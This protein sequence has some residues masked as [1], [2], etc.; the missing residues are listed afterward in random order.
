MKGGM[1]F[2]RGSGKAARAYVEADHHRADDYYLSEGE[3]VAELLVVEGRSGEVV[4]RAPMD[5][6]DYEGWVQG[7]DVLADGQS[8]KGRIRNDDHALRFAEVVVNGP[9]SWSLAAGLHPDVAAAYDAAQDE[10]S[11]DIARWLGRNVTTRVGRRGDQRQVRAERVD[12]ARI[13]HFTT[14]AGDPHRHIH[15]QVNARVRAGGKWRGIDSAA[16]LRMQRAINGIGHRSVMSNPMFREALARHGYTLDARSGEIDQLAAVVPAM[17]KRSQQVAA[18]IERYTREWRADNPGLEPDAALLRTW[19]ARAWADEREAKKNHPTRGVECEQAWRAELAKL[20]VNVAGHQTAGPVPVAAVLPGA[21][22]RDEAAQRVVRVL[23]AG[24]RGRSMWNTYDVRGVAEEVLT[25]RGLV[26]DKAAIDEL[27]EDVVDRAQAASLVVVDQ[28]VPA[29]VRSMT[30]Q[31]VIDLERDIQGRLAARALE[32]AEL[33]EVAALATAAPDAQLD[34]A[35]LQAARTIAGTS[36]VV[37]VEGA[38][39]T[40]KSTMLAAANAAVVA[41]GHSMMVVAPS[42]NAALIAA[43]KVGAAHGP[44]AAGLAFQHGYRWDEDGVWSRLTPGD[45]CPLTDEP[46]DGP[47]QWAQLSPGDVLVIDEAGMLDQETARALLTVADEAQ[48]RV[49]FMGDRRQLP[50]VGRGG[51]MQVVADWAPA[52]VELDAVH[53]FR[54]PDGDRDA[55]YAELSQRMRSG[56]NPA[57]VFDELFAGGHVQLHETEADALAAIALTAADRVIADESQSIAVGT[58]EHAEAINQIVRERLV[59]A[60]IVD[61]DLT[62]LGSDGLRIGVGDQVV[63]RRNDNRLG[64]A[65]RMRWTVTAVDDAGAVILARSD[66]D[67]VTVEPDYVQ[68]NLHLAYASTAHGVQGD[69][70]DHGDKLLTDRTDAPAAYVGLTRG[71]QSNTLHVVARTL[72]DARE[73]WVAAAGRGRP[74]IGLANAQAIA[75]GEAGDYAL[76]DSVVIEEARDVREVLGVA[77]RH[78]EQQPVEQRTPESTQG[79]SRRRLEQI[80]ERSIARTARPIG[81]AGADNAAEVSQDP[82]Q[83]REANRRRWEQLRERSQTRAARPIGEQAENRRPGEVQADDG[84]DRALDDHRHER[85]GYGPRR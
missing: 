80:R 36:A 37:L 41:D 29:H 75:A 32:P 25:A 9:K 30:S 73:Q 47:A 49:V 14:R 83:R 17:S 64:I 84:H 26:A 78:S 34:P 16:L 40:G 77:P 18:N 52:P 79:P 23:A 13:R 28:P 51:I 7:R 60:G 68:A 63:T 85:G 15:L 5:G 11:E 48:A 43:E 33:I 65:N 8:P 53:R 72:D 58:N 22:D 6:D 57:G 54:S 81:E 50:A 19:D 71:Q 31:E 76:V 59:D 27:V 66:R 24:A 1:K 21:I 10:A 82:D 61:D 39:G 69:T 56:Q 62:T 42:R 35:Q 12:V 45:V 46:W 67:P 2:Y 74:D 55:V 38:A 44:A 4:D 20:G 70:S 3:G